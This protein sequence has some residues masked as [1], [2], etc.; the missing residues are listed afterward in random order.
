MKRKLVPF[1]EYLPR[2]FDKLLG[3]TRAGKVIGNYSPGDEKVR[4][5]LG[6]HLVEVLIC[7]EAF[8]PNLVSED[9]DG[10]IVLSNQ[11]W[12]RGTSVVKLHE[13]AIWYLALLKR[14]QVVSVVRKS[15]DEAEVVM[16]TYKSS[17][18]E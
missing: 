16:Y 2:P 4:I 6:G 13:K 18:E 12:Y 8:F 14:A 7:S 15:L 5:D 9:T 3:F 11:M 17:R 1:G 10:I